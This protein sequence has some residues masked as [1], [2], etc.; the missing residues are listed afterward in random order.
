M[1]RAANPTKIP[2]ARAPQSATV[3]D[4][5]IAHEVWHQIEGATE[6]RSY[7]WGVELRRRLGEHLGVATLE[8][9]I[10]GRAPGAADAWR[11][12]NERLAREA[13]P[14]AATLPREATAELF[15]L[16]WLMPEEG[17]TPVVRAFGEAVG[18]LLP[19]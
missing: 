2:P 6:A 14:Y 16:W 17:R 8:H 5:I 3:L 9:A 13:S 18:A 15:M 11:H 7:A 19:G 12:A 4:G 10:L 1:K